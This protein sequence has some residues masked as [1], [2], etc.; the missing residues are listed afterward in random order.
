MGCFLVPVVHVIIILRFNVELA[1]CFSSQ[2]A[3]KGIFENSSFSKSIFSLVKKLR[4]SF[5]LIS[6]DYVLKNFTLFMVTI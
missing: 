4:R 3:K 5:A 6:D 2:K 1:L